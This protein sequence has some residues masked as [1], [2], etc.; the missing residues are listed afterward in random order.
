MFGRGNVREGRCPR[1]KAAHA[2]RLFREIAEEKAE[3]W[4]A[5]ASAAEAWATLSQS[6]QSK[7][8]AITYFVSGVGQ[9]SPVA[10]MTTGPSD[11]CRAR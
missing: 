5:M 8:V 6:N 2:L 10:L 11:E 1:H 9:R 3:A 4:A 7:F